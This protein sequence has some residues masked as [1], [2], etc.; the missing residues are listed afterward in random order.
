MEQ[1]TRKMNVVP[2]E[3]KKKFDETLVRNLE[4]N[5]EA[6]RELEG[7]SLSLTA[8][9]SLVL[10]VE[11][12][13][14]MEMFPEDSPG[15]FT[16]D[17]FFNELEKVVL[18]SEEEV[19]REIQQMIEKGYVDVESDGSLL[20]QKPAKDMARLLDKAFPGMP[21]MNLVAYL[22]QTLDEA[23]SGRKKPEFAILQLEQTLQMHGG[24]NQK[25][26]VP[27]R[28]G[29]PQK[30]G[31]QS[32]YELKSA[33]SETLRK[34]KASQ[35]EQASPTA[36]AQ[37]KIVIAGGAVKPLQVK[38]VFAKKGGPLETP[39]APDGDTGVNTG[40]E[41]P[42]A[43][44]GHAVLPEH[45]NAIG[46]EDIHD[47]VESL[48]E[49]TSS[50]PAAVEP[51]E[52]TTGS[53]APGSAETEEEKVSP[54]SLAGP[55]EETDDSRRLLLDEQVVEEDLHQ[56][57]APTVET[58]V[59][60]DTASQQDTSALSDEVLEARIAALEQNL[61]MTC[62]I[63]GAGKVETKET[64]KGKTFYVCIQQ[65][66]VFVSWG[67]PYHLECPWCKNP[68]LIETT[69]KAGKTILRCPRA[70]C[71]YQQGMLGEGD[72][73]LAK[74]AASAQ[75]ATPSTTK[76]VRRSRKKKR[77]VRRRVV[78]RKR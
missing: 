60:A 46:S 57:V 50:G 45:S 14:E 62:P 30:T 10:L 38:E 65:D 39:P 55:A 51:E 67:K 64:A 15:R 36:K 5:L 41:E 16:K 19:R 34:R 29:S 24:K 52:E 74:A 58:S 1:D 40:E 48:S 13:S 26:A 78:R 72:P 70:T 43:K 68:Y 49:E 71:R 7:F 54:R 4:G 17:T 59:E 61:A 27:G 47:D 23:L 11:R 2:E 31:G 9:S 63:C 3:V 73:S 77:V 25:R 69:G 53:L 21:G 42:L 37:P 66:C 75:G 33:L 35:K 56:Q 20:A 8:V 18:D 28:E 6:G 44:D 22:V 12:E 76:V 32:A